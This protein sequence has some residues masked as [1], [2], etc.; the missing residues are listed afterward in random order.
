M[1]ELQERERIMRAMWAEMDRQCAIGAGEWHT[2]AETGLMCIKADLD[3]IAMAV[4]LTTPK[5]S[6]ETGKVA[7]PPEV[8]AHI[9]KI[10]RV[11]WGQ[12]HAHDAD[13]HGEHIARSVRLTA[14][15]F[16]QEGDQHMHGLWVE[17]TE[18]VVAHTGTSP[19]AP[20]TTQALVGMWNWF[21]DQAALSAAPSAPA[22]EAQIALEYAIERMV[23]LTPTRANAPTAHDLHIATRAIGMT[24]LEASPGYHDRPGLLNTDP[25]TP[26]D[27]VKDGKGGGA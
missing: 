22:T 25:A 3:P 18:T 24:A 27:Q 26:T 7:L 2:D 5:A 1:T 19:N 15:T 23:M 20:A 16:A 12:T 14:E 17:G 8:A 4:A 21:H 10:G 9:L 11:E 6:A 13:G